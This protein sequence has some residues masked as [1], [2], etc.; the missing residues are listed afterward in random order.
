MVRIQIGAKFLET[1][2]ASAFSIKITKQIKDFTNSLDNKSSFSIDFEVPPTVSNTE[3]LFNVSDVNAVGEVG[4]VDCFIIL[5]GQQYEKGTLFAFESEYNGNFTCTYQS[6]LIEWADLLSA[7]NLNQTVWKDQDTSTITEEATDTFSSARVDFLN[8]QVADTEDITY[9]LINRNNGLEFESKRPVLYG[10][11]LIQRVF[12]SIGWEAFGSWLDSEELTGGEIVQDKFGNDFDF[13][14]LLYDP[15]FNFEIDEEIIEANRTQVQSV[16]DDVDD[17]VIDWEAAYLLGNKGSLGTPDIVTLQ[18]YEGLFTD[19]IIDPADNWEPSNS[20]YTVPKS[21]IFLLTLTFGAFKYGLKNTETTSKGFT[22]V[23]NPITRRPPRIDFFV[24]ANNSGNTTING[25]VLYDT[26]SST[27]GFTWEAGFT[28]IPISFTAGDEISIFFKIF[29][30]AYGYVN[31]DFNAPSLNEWVFRMS[32][33]M[34]IN[35]QQKPVLE[36]GDVFRINNHIP[37]INCLSII[38]DMRLRHNL[39][40]VTNNEDKKVQIETWNNYYKGLGEAKNWTN[41]IDLTRAPKINLLSDYR[42]KLTFR[43]AVDGSDGYL[44]RWQK[45][46]QITYGKYDQVLL[47]PQRFEEGSTVYQTD[48]SAAT[49]QGN[50]IGSELNSSVIKEEWITDE[51]TGIN[52][53]YAPRVFY[54]IYGKQYFDDGQERAA[55][56]DLYAL[57]ESYGNMPIFNDLRLTFAGD[58]G[59]YIREWSKTVEMIELGRKVDAYFKISSYEFFN[60]DFSEPIFLEYPEKLKG[61]YLVQSFNNFDVNLDGKITTELTLIKYRNFVGDNLDTSQQTNVNEN[62]NNGQ[63]QRNQVYTVTDEGLPSEE[64]NQVFAFLPNGQRVLVTT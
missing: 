59:L 19:E 46:N 11:K 63:T 12:E 62:T 39:I 31:A 38:K 1:A 25:V 10:K 43:Y 32:D 9:P 34:I 49:I 33:N 40:F 14:G 48:L 20:V 51:E 36:E 52:N 35:I 17:F 53:G 56:P 47:N 50:L 7:R 13:K 3:M 55:T 42:K 2:D 37:A 8:Q 18:R 44:E 30:D 45:I 41:K 23:S 22:P 61:Y 16:K 54:G 64:I 6:G 5:D 28:D 24:V 27:F 21:G 57:M 58:N 26:T 4:V 60:F 29:D 15:A